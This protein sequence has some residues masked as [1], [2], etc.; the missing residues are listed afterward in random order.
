[1]KIC[2]RLVA[3]SVCISCVVRML[4][5]TYV[6]FLIILFCLSFSYIF[7]AVLIYGE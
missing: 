5:L 2:D 3:N 1:M 7:A 6:C 4:F